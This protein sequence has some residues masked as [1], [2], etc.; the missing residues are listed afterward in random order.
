MA[1]AE[2]AC[3]VSSF[4]LPSNVKV[5]YAVPY[6][7]HSTFGDPYDIAYPASTTNLPKFCATYVNV[8]TSPSSSFRFALWLPAEWNSRYLAVGNGGFGGGENYAAM[9]PGL[10]Y[11]FA[12]S[13][14]DNGHNSSLS[15][16]TWAYHEPE[17]VIDWGYRAV[18]QMTV[19]SKQMLQQYYGRQQDYAYDPRYDSTDW[20]V[21]ERLLDGRQAGPE[22]S[23]NVPR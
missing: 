23:T 3:S 1:H 19:L 16:G 9:G 22:R 2:L 18:H 17:T 5:L 8:T 10:R 20:R 11:G 15:D 21:L 4:N 12:V 13:S 6:A 7:S 14:T